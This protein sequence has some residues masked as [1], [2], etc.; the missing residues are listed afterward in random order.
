M[1]LTVNYINTELNMSVI[2]IH[3]FWI[4]KM[5]MVTLMLPDDIENVEERI[6][7][8]VKSTTNTLDRNPINCLSWYL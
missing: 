3:F 2:E 6:V 7:E 1:E 5:P 4:L 8:T